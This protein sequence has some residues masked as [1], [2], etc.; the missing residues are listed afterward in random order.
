MEKKGVIVLL[1]D[2]RELLQ[3]LEKV[4][5]KK[6][7]VVRCFEDSEVALEYV[8]GKNPADVLVSDIRMPGM[9]GM[10]ILK[11]LKQLPLTP[12]VVMMTA[13]GTIEN[14]VEAMKVGAFEY[15]TKPFHV[16][17]LLIIIERAMEL[18][19]LRKEVKKLRKQ[20]ESS[21]SVQGLISKNKVMQSVFSSV[22]RMA[23]EKNPILFVGSSG[24][25]KKF[26]G[27]V[28]HKSGDRKNFPFETLSCSAVPRGMQALQI[29]GDKNT[30]G[31]I[32]TADGGI[33]FLEEIDALSPDCQLHLFHYLETG[34]FTPW[35][36]D[37]PQTSDVRI[38]ASL[39]RSPD[40]A[41]EPITLREDLYYKLSPF[42]VILPELKSRREDILFLTE[43][44]MQSF[45]KENDLEP[46]E[47]SNEAQKAL[48]NYSW[49]G[50]VRELQNVIERA[51]VLSAENYIGVDDLP[52][53]IV[54][55]S[56]VAP[57]QLPANFTLTDLEKAYIYQVL[58]ENNNHQGRSASLLG[59][60]R[61]TLYRKIR[62]YFPE[63]VSKK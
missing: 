26:L 20:M 33:L 40:D 34:T 21:Y 7:Y 10:E 1:D 24:T 15:L 52:P 11:R 38:I 49:P 8:E 5:T 61:K 53:Q 4:L 54:R 32:K 27:R 63:M 46:K 57:S 60:D 30:D 12:P 41:V 37:R 45:C 13:Y 29:F 6:G 56:Q 50:N 14:A 36:A 47:F 58:Q 35:F 25:G 2:E 16:D 51:T 48:L 28:I 42:M 31:L 62:E 22:S 3:S 18:T 59:I 43:A 19:Y 39:L 55:L 23:S 44:F 9:D 17:E